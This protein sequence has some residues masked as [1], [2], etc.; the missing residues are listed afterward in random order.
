MTTRFLI[1]IDR[2]IPIVLR[3]ARIFPRTWRTA[4]TCRRSGVPIRFFPRQSGGENSSRWK[5]RERNWQYS[6]SRLYAVLDRFSSRQPARRSRPFLYDFPST[7]CPVFLSFSLVFLSQYLSS[8]FRPPFSRRDIIYADEQG[9]AAQKVK[10]EPYGLSRISVSLFRESSPRSTGRE[11]GARDDFSEEIRRAPFRESW[12]A[13]RSPSALGPG[14]RGRH[15]DSA[16]RL[17]ARGIR[18]NTP[19]FLCSGRDP[20]LRVPRPCYYP[21][22]AFVLDRAISIA[23]RLFF[24]GGFII[25]ATICAEF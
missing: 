12:R 7:P 4:R 19:V 2:V 13:A 23:A 17:Q 11:R 1:K 5:Q 6:G 22:G 21:A 18:T 20:G 15:G 9:E 24:A 16:S 25:G 14:W 8:F 3:R 10:R